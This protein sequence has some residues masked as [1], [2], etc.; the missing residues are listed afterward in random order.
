MQYT[1]LI[2]KILKFDFLI[3]N[4]KNISIKFI[5]IKNK[6]LEKLKKYIKVFIKK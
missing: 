3:L 5:Y 2:I 6:F 1:I 4:I